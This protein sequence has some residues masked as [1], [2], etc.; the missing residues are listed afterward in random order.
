MKFTDRFIQRPVLAVVVNVLILLIGARAFQALSVTQFPEVSNAIVTVTT[1]YPGADAELVKGFVTTPLEQAIAQ[2]EGIDYMTSSTVRGLST[3]TAHLVT[4]YDANDALTQINTKINQVRNDLP[5]GS[6]LPSINVQVG[7]TAAVFY[8]SYTSDVLDRNQVTDWVLRVAQP[9][10][11]TVPG[12]QSADMLG[13]RVYA[14]RVWLDPG[15]M[16]ALRVTASDVREALESNNYLGAAGAVKGRSE[17]FAITA[18]TSLVDVNEFKRLV[19]REVNDTQIRLGDVAEV[20][21]GAESYSADVRVNGRPGTFVAIETAPL[22]NLLETLAGVRQAFEELS[23][24]MPPGIEGRINRDASVYV[25]EAID[26]VLQTLVEALLIVVVVIYLFLGSVRS[27]LIP[28]VAVPLSLIGVGTLM[29]LLGFNINLLTLLAM[30]LA[31]GL[32]VDDAIIVVE[33]IHRHIEAGLSPYDAS[34]KGAR[35]L[36]GP[37]I[38]MTL[39]L[40]SVYAPIG[41]VGGI[42]GTLFTEFAFTLAG[43]VLISGIVALTLSPMMCAK[44]LKPAEQEGRLAHWLDD[45]FSALRRGYQRVLHGALNFRPLIVLT[46]AGLLVSCYFLYQMIPSEL[47]P[48]EDDGVLLYSVEATPNTSLDQLAVYSD[49]LI[50]TVLG[51]PEVRNS[52]HFSGGAAGQTSTAFGGV[53]FHGSQQRERTAPELLPEIQ[54]AANNVTGVRIGVFPLPSLPGGGRGVPVQFAVTTTQ[55][56]AALYDAAE[57]LLGRARASGLFVF[58]TSNLKFDNAQM[59]L[60]IDRAKAID[61]GL[62]MEQLG[63]DL[64][65]YLGDGYVNR[66][67]LAG[68]AYKVIPQVERPARLNPEQMLSYPIRTD[69][70]EMLPLSSV[71]SLEKRVEP[72]ELLTFQQ[73]NAATIAA[74]PAPG[75]SIGEALAFLEQTAREVL[76]SGFAF[77]YGGQSRQFKSEQGGMLWTFLFAIIIIFLVLAAQFESFRDPLIML[78]TVPL[79]IS[80]ALLFLALGY[81]TMN[82]YTQV[83]LVTL[84]GLIS[85]HGILIVQFANQLRQE[86]GLDRRA[87]VEEACAIRLRPILMTTAAIVLAVMPLVLASGAGAVARSAIGIVVATGMTVGTVFT[88]FVVPAVYTYLAH[89]SVASV[90]GTAQSTFEPEPSPS[91]G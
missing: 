38:A 20:E 18:N 24:S 16:A 66:F 79:S 71:A 55:P 83:G 88:L 45:R 65:V 22:A 13:G 42:T 67:N 2:A 69:S 4:D 78:V 84:I 41:F 80:G 33:N 19:I 89:R 14:M 17:S 90:G 40:L 1:V 23:E 91:I 56:P 53:G 81:G 31:I 12:V 48:L 87:A 82:I 34:I 10:Y 77:D 86:Q 36:A 47:A 11:S 64:A 46:G 60:E 75:V 70:G 25:Q 59:H 85:K 28:A 52:F 74:I 51:F 15:R 35:E 44:L 21:L 72:R 57:A 58:S 73:L 27:T 8:A 7:A 39:T 76:P 9:R 63:K 37:V 61:L 49:Q 32:V 54:R 68:R 62:D 43:S 26:E 50:E 29:L 5:A 3:I 30:V 6:E